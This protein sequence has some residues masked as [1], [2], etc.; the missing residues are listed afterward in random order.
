MDIPYQRLQ[1]ALQSAQQNTATRFV[2]SFPVRNRDSTS[3]A[4]DFDTRVPIIKISYPDGPA[5][6]DQ[7]TVDTITQ[8]VTRAIPGALVHVRKGPNDY[9]CIEAPMQT[10]TQDTPRPP[11]GRGRDRDD[12]INR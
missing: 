11:S 4:R 10:Q 7:A 1:R 9:Y 3:W 5:T 8:F 12:H 6:R 2:Y